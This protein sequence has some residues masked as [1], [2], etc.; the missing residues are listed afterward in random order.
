MSLKNLRYILKNSM[1]IITCIWYKNGIYLSMLDGNKWGPPFL[2]SDSAVADF[3]ALIDSD[4]NISTCYVDYMDRLIYMPVGEEKKEPVVL[5]ESR[6]CGSSPYSVRMAGADGK[7]HIFYIVNHNRR[8]L[9]T[10]QRLEGTAYTMPEVEGVIVRDAKNYAVC[11]DGYTVHIFFV[12]NIQNVNLLVHRSIFDGKVSKPVTTPFPYND[13]HILQAVACKNGPVYV[14]ASLEESDGKTLLFRYDTIL[15]KFSKGLEV[16]NVS[17]GPGSDSLI[18]VRNAPYVIRTLKNAFVV[19]AIKQDCS[20][21]EAES[22]IDLTGRDI[23]LKCKFQ[24]THTEDT[25][26]KSDITPMLFGNGLS[27]PFDIN[28]LAARKQS[29][30]ENH[31]LIYVRIRELENRIEFLENTIRGLLKP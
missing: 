25:F 18:A 12:T 4:D 3:S 17:V 20:K 1:G 28:K 2:I 24:S 22:K 19:S 26:F 15:N 27:F 29:S 8:Q 16:F 21:V 13:S 9:L 14:L 23:P 30:G 11:S 10:Y 6:I 7:I 5:L 31:D